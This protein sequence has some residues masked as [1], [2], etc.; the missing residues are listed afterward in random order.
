MKAK[1]EAIEYCL[2]AN[3]VSNEQ[4]KKENPTWDIEL[5]TK[6]IGVKSRH[7]A[8]ENETAL[9]LAI[10]A[11]SKL[12]QNNQGL[13]EK[14][15]ALIFCTESEDYILPPDSCLL[16]KHFNLPENVFA[17]DFNLACSGYIYGL[18]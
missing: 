16:H 13:K 18:Y 2:P 7:I 15:D 4:L 10:E 12:F 11:C 6:R 17:F 8:T 14:I 3:I 9:D 1:I 5:L